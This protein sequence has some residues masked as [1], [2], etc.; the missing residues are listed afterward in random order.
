MVLMLEEA[1][2]P[3]AKLALPGSISPSLHTLTIDGHSESES[4]E[5]D[6]EQTSPL[7]AQDPPPSYIDVQSFR[8]RIK[9]EER[10]EAISRAWRRFWLALALTCLFVTLSTSV[11]L[12]I[13][14]PFSSQNELPEVSLLLP[15]NSF[16]IP[17]Y[18]F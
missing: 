18:K 1:D 17:Q 5:D 12:A 11:C 8:E 7:I 15:Q 14:Y 3:E 10:A 4:S 16:L 2:D 9:E 13:L 6:N